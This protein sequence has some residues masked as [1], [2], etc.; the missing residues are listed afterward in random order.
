[1]QG[2]GPATGGAPAAARSS[3]LRLRVASALVLVPLA[4]GSAYLGGWPFAIFWGVAA[5][6][7]LWEWLALACGRT[8]PKVL[9]AGGVA[10]V[11]ALVLVGTG[12]AD[13]AGLAALAGAAAAAWLGPWDA[14]LWTAGGVVYAGALLIAVVVLRA[15]AALGFVAIVFLFAVVWATDILAYFVGRALGG[16]K[17]WPAVSPKKTWSGALGGSL[18]AVLA[19]LAVLWPDNVAAAGKIAAI[20]FVL[21]AVSQAGDLFESHLKRQFNAKDSS[22]LIPGHGGVMD[23]IDGFVTAVT[24]AVVIGLLR[25]GGQ[26]PAAGLIAW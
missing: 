13:L 25:S 17:L 24:A 16:P 15:D 1:M 3:D 5:A 12:R 7:V 11:A 22:A 2:G 9:G 14:R 26:S 6:G 23:R 21:S 10:L 8:E 20:A 19:G 18:A 4:V